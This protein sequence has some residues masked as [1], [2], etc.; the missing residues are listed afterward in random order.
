MSEESTEPN[1]KTI[2]E[3]IDN[4]ANEVAL[5]KQKQISQDAQF[6]AIRQGLVQNSSAFDLLESVVLKVGSD[7]ANLKADVKDLTE[8]VHQMG[9]SK[10]T[11]G[12]K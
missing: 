5:I 8:E 1:L 10:E 9:K 2:L 6:K 11:L 4:L 12:L 7:V 3:A